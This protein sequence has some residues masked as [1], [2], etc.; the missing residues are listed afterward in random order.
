MT[1]I[2]SGESTYKPLNIVL[3]RNIEE[4]DQAL[5][6]LHRQIESQYRSLPWPPRIQKVVVLTAIQGGNGD[7]VG[8]GKTIAMLQRLCPTLTFDWVLQG[9]DLNPQEAFKFLN[10]QDKSKVNP[11]EWES[12]PEDNTP[13]ELLFTGPVKLCFD[14][15]YIEKGLSRKIAGPTF[16]FIENG[17][18]LHTF[19]SQ[20]LP[21]LVEQSSGKPNQAI[22]QDLH[23]FIFPNK[24]GHS[25]GLIP[26]G[27]LP[28]SGVFLDK[29]RME[30]P[31][32]RG[33]CCPSYLTQ[34]Q[35]L[36]LRKDIL[37][38]MAIFDGQSQPDYDQYSF[39]S[40]YA[41]RVV[42]WGKFIDCVA[43][44]EKGKHVVMV[45]N[46]SGTLAKLSNQEFQEQILGEERLAFL[47]R[48]GYGTIVFKG[49]DQ[50]T[51][52][53]KIGENSRR[54]IVV[55]RPAFSPNDMRLLQLASERLL[56]TGDNSAVE[57]WCSKC[58]L[59]V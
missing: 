6:P 52:Y 20:V 49:Q 43:I 34:I 29:S 50:N 5:F 12:Q 28:G 26:M 45:L 47:Q 9:T 51:V 16:G 19:F 8:A 15:K 38:A 48:K 55:V 42:S 57:A 56:A 59:Y 44:H 40:G 23:S 18:F 4:L 30:A 37:E 58:K 46:Q 24:S 3:P 14:P 22:Y 53:L 54:F 41:Q 7:F 1:P 2:S 33:Y 11:R 27:L 21:T 17:G 36:E 31:L 13:G 25:T 32:T 35:D 39:N 10:S